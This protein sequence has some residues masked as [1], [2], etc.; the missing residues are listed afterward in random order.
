M[1][2]KIGSNE[3]SNKKE[4]GGRISEEEEV[5]RISEEAFEYAIEDDQRLLFVIFHRTLE[6]PQS[7]GMSL[8]KFLT[9]DLESWWF[10]KFSD[11]F[12]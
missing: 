11:E 8:K 3:I 6:F 9:Q 4:E 5:C 1:K 10:H 12:R 7:Y 2:A